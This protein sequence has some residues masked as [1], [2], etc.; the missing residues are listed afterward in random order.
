MPNYCINEI[1]ITGDNNK[2]IGITKKIKSSKNGLLF[3]TLIGKHPK[4]T[5]ENWYEKNCEWFGCKWDVI[6]N[7]CNIEFGD[8][9]II[10][11][12]QT[13][14]SPPEPFCKT[15]SQKF[16]VN[17]EI[18]YFEPGMDFAGRSEFYN[19]DLIDEINYDDCQ[20]GKYELNN[21][22]FW[23]DEECDYLDEDRLDGSTLDEYIE[24][25]YSFLKESDV[26]RLK[27][28]LQELLNDTSDKKN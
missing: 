22:R 7:E 4:Y 17:V 5:D 25:Y 26:P 28:I 11:N 16:N 1:K 2:I 23:Q 14:W 21:E 20:E 8:D 6:I 3:E 18:F 10:I 27:Q 15:L 24:I 13:A 12:P 9:F 19:G